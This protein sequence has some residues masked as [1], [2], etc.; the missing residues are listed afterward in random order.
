[1]APDDV[2]PEVE[3]PGPQT[4]SIPVLRAVSADTPLLSL[5]PGVEGLL[6]KPDALPF[7]MPAVEELKVRLEGYAIEL[8]GEA[9]RI[10]R[11]QQAD[12]ISPAYVRQASDILVARKG[13][14]RIA[15]AGSFGWVL[16]G[17]ALPTLLDVVAV[18][19]MPSVQ[20]VGSAILGMLGA[21][22]IAVQVFRE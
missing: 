2:H 5:G 16:V 13:R 3:P 14:K 8:V 1:M 21:F 6:S 7:S 15:L 12:V 10:T 17:A 9:Q 22:L 11:R 4:W 20:I 19:P 18:K